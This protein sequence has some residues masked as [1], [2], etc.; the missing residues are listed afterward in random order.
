MTAL[1]RELR[2]LG[3]TLEWPP[4]PD[5]VAAVGSR[6]QPAARTPW[7]RRRAVLAVAAAAIVAAVVA[8]LAVP[9]ARTSVLHWLG[10][11]SVRIVQVDELRPT[12]T[13]GPLPGQPVTLAE[14][15]E[16]APFPLLEPSSE[17]GT[18]DL[19]L[20]GS[21]GI[22][23]YV[24]GSPDAPRLAV[25][26]LPGSPAPWLV[27]KLVPSGVPIEE[28]TID[29]RPAIWIGATHE[30]AVLDGRTGAEIWDIARLAGPT[31]LVDRG[32]QTLR[33]EGDLT[34]EQAV[35]VARAFR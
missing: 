3:D 26:Q 34:R 14:A 22:V 25:S 15:R 10:L 1:E 23:T 2:A 27:G 21:H 33:V 29:D 5:V 9:S 28:L 12:T 24:W 17:L 35:R 11:G 13:T 4:A 6:L 7:W 18:P 20:V 16:S 32:D 30:V 19:V 8:T 31:L